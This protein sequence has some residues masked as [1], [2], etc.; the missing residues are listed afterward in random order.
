MNLNMYMYNIHC[1]YIL[2]NIYAHSLASIVSLYILY[3]YI[4]VIHLSDCIGKRSFY[5]N[6]PVI[7]TVI[8]LVFYYLFRLIYSFH[9]F[10]P[11]DSLAFAKYF[12]YNLS[13]L[14]NIMIYMFSVIQ[15]IFYIQQCVRMRVRAFISD[16]DDDEDGGGGGFYRVVFVLVVVLLLLLLFSVLYV[17][18]S[19]V[20]KNKY[21]YIYIYIYIQ[22]CL[23]IKIYVYTYIMIDEE[24]NS[25][26]SYIITQLCYAIFWT[27][28]KKNNFQIYDFF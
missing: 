25:K 17:I 4:L 19:S 7:E 2:Y 3:I 16:D 11:I 5:Y 22:S 18:L 23:Y 9:L 15:L 1:I 8:L 24:Q 6:C 13:M 10:C 12:P 20:Y 21:T 28:E 14:H 26:L 27:V